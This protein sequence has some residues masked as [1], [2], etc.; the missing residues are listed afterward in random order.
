MSQILEHKTLQSFEMIRSEN[1]KWSVVMDNF[2]TVRDAMKFC[3]NVE[4]ALQWKE[5][6]EKAET[7]VEAIAQPILD[8]R[9]QFSL[10]CDGIA[11]LEKIAKIKDMDIS[12]VMAMMIE[13]ELD[14][15]RNNPDWKDIEVKTQ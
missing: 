4:T 12:E 10:D 1:E 13:N 8:G 15:C 5:D 7:E 11:Q 2:E 9:P 14:E 3:N 6:F